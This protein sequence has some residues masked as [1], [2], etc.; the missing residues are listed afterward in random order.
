VEKNN[1]MT[2]TKNTLS[3][4]DKIIAALSYVWL[5]FLIPMFLKKNNAFCQF[6]AKQGLILFLCSLVLY[7]VG[8]IPVLGWLIAFVGWISVAIFSI[9]GIVNSLQ[10]IK[11]EIPIL[12]KYAKKID[13]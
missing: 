1:F 6:H 11:W 8:A 4:D 3:Q 13:L 2:D 12:G 10:G 5:L 9:L 7:V